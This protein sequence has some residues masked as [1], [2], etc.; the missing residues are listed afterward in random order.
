MGRWLAG[1]LMKELG[2]VGCQQ[3]THRYKRSGHEHVAIPNYLYTGICQITSGL[4]F[5]RP[6]CAFHQVTFPLVS[7]HCTF[8]PDGLAHYHSEPA[9]HQDPTVM[10]QDR[11]TVFYGMLPDKIRSGLFYE[12]LADA[13]GLRGASPLFS[14]V[15]YR[16]LPDK[17]DNHCSRCFSR[18]SVSSTRLSCW[19][20]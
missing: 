12:S 4:N 3:P 13:V 16:L 6:R 1:R 19:Y 7:A 15:L 10:Y 14:C 18:A 20:F 2:L 9:I 8:F 17:A 11:R 5:S